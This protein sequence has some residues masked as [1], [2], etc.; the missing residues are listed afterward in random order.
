MPMYRKL[1]KVGRLSRKNSGRLETWAWYLNTGMKSGSLRG[2][3]LATNGFVGAHGS[4]FA[5]SNSSTLTPA[6]TSIRTAC[7]SADLCF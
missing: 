7:T 3:F 4:I 6:L 2:H 5:I 1:A